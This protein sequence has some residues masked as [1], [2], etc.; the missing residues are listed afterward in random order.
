MTL[1]P[2]RDAL[3]GLPAAPP[4]FVLREAV[5]QLEVL[6]RCGAMV[7]HGGANSVHEAL[8]AGVPLAVVPIFGDQPSN[9]DA[10]AR[11]G[12][13][14]SF[15]HPLSTLTA[16]ALREAVRGLLRAGGANPYGAAARAVAKTL[17]AAGGVPAAADAVLELAAAAGAG[18]A[19]RMGGA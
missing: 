6:Q 17:E 15:R 19:A 8:R 4:N 9:A 18:A 12:A 13:G 2:R 7:T 1:G 5:P 10:V 16:A 11:A 14:V 3:E